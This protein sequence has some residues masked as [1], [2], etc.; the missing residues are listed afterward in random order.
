LGY[1]AARQVEA[2]LL[3]VKRAGD[4]P[5]A[6]FRNRLMFPIYDPQ[7]R[8]IAFGGRVIGSGEPKYLNSA[9][10]PTFQKGSTLY[11]L[12]WAKNA[13]RKDERVLLV[14]GYFDC[15]RLLAAGIESTIAPL[16]TA[17]TEAQADLLRK[18]TSNVYLLYDS[19]KAGLKATFRAGDVL[20]RQGFKVHVVT[21]PEGDDPDSYV[22]RYG[23]DKLEG[24]LGAAIDVYERKLQIL[25]RRGWFSDLRRKRVALDRLLPTIR[26]AADPITFALYVSRTAEVAGISAEV[27]QRE[28]RGPAGSRIP[29]RAG[30]T[31][32]TRT[33]QP[34][35]QLRVDTAYGAELWLVRLLLTHKQFLEPAAERVSVKEFRDARL[36]AIF[37]QLL[38]RTTDEYFNAVFDA[39]PEHAQDLYNHLES[40]PPMPNPQIV[41]DE[42]VAQ[43]KVRG[44]ADML[45]AIQREL[46]LADDVEKN[47][48]LQRQ[49]KL[50]NDMRAMGGRRWKMTR[51]S[52]Q[53]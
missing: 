4:E 13:I 24:Q 1:D 49:R 44:I 19:D 53:K 16:G 48:I 46:P 3:V 36:R 29:E 50:F 17:L 22:A 33:P 8:V 30:S 20:L 23:R 25:Q 14:E 43:I 34:A 37:T 31:I 38:G 35:K 32:A 51:T 52:H 47:E 40:Q 18:Y 26:S 5:H 28:L 11:G 6:R 27:L 21:L 39:L 12:N 10:S 2:G 7:G 9:E 42:S 15:V 45:D 41:F